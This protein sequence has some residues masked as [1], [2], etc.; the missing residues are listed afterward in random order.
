MVFLAL[1]LMV[2]SC[3][4]SYKSTKSEAIRERL[5]GG[6]FYCYLGGSF[7]MDTELRLED[8]MFI[9]RNG[10]E[11]SY[12]RWEISSDGKYLH[13]NGK[14]HHIESDSKWVTRDIFYVAV[15]YKFKIKNANTLILE[16]Y[17]WPYRRVKDNKITTSK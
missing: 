11:N 12:G 3:S 7:G 10:P 4:A 9:F 2:S 14:Q 16:K 8:S 1:S 6:Y 17:K 5:I 15:N 13:I